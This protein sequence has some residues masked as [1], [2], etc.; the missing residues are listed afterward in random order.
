[1]NAPRLG[2]FS[3]GSPSPPAALKQGLRWLSDRG[4]ACVLGRTAI[5]GEGLHAGPPEARAADLHRLLADPGVDAVLCTR[6]GSGSLGLLPYLDFEA[7]VR[8]GKPLIGMSDVTA[9]HLALYGRGLHGIS[10]AMVVQLDAQTA[11]YTAER[12][13]ALVSARPSG[14]QTKPAPLLPMPAGAA[15]RPLPQ[16]GPSGRTGTSVAG[17]EGPLLPCNLSLLAALVGTPFLP[18]LAGTILV[19]EDIH[20]TPQSIDRMLAQ[21]T[22]SGVDRQPAGL[23][24]GQFTACLPRGDNVTE[25]DG[26][27]RLWQWAGSLGVP[28]LV[29]FPYGHEPV[30]CALPF[31][32]RARLTLD[33]PGL[34]LLESPFG[35]G[36]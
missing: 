1:V 29:D 30:T 13:L 31:G 18:S 10:G 5:G 14:A 28:A 22:L 24:L 9:L 4:F 34:Q 26:R 33:P 16:T 27:Q 25:A 23:V 35:A 3:P 21:L 11:A 32:A 15:P 7:A 8:A 12:W 2:I 6:G 36:A 20:E 17:V 19:L